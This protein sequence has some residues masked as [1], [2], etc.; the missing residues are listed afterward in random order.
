MLSRT[1]TIVLSV[2]VAAAP[3]VVFAAAT[4]WP[5]HPKWML[6][7]GVTP[8]RGDGESVDSLLR[9]VTGP[10]IGSTRF[11]LVDTMRIVEWAP[12]MRCAVRHTGSVVRGDA[13]FAVTP[14]SDGTSVFTWSERLDL[15]LGMLG[16][17]GWAILRPVF[18]VGLTVSLRRFAAWAP[19]ASATGPS[20]TGA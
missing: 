19:Q 1:A 20:S 9:A 17:V 7:T 8:T 18:V 12:P 2:D 13:Q 16:A 4:D 10:R 6:L 14:R 11:G 15:P 5:G 3:D